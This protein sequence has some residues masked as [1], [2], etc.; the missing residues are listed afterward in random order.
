MKNYLLI[1]LITLFV[2]C[3]KEVPADDLNIIPSQPVYFT[4]EAHDTLPKSVHIELWSVKQ[5]TQEKKDLVA[6]IDTTVNIHGK[7]TFTLWQDVKPV[8]Y[9]IASLS[10]KPKVGSDIMN[11]QIDSKTGMCVRRASSCPTDQ[12]AINNE[13]ISLY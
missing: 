1:L 10:V 9:C 2:C 7:T 12:Y 6:I 4:V 8:I 3:K 5:G 13:Y 11:L